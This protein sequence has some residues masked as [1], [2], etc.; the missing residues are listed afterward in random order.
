MAVDD[1]D[2]PGVLK[3]I[4]DFT[5]DKIERVRKWFS[6]FRADKVEGKK[7]ALE[8][9]LTDVVILKRLPP[10]GRPRALPAEPLNA[11]KDKV[12]QVCKEGR[13]INRKTLED[14]LA[15]AIK[16]RAHG[17]FESH[18]VFVRIFLK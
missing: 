11:L 3:R 10:R 17:K 18:P 7:S 13:T 1:K 5:G 8:P 16:E 15:F 4:A 9:E 6:S 2:V 12:T 14:L